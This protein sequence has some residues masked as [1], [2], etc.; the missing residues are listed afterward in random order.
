MVWSLGDVNRKGLPI[1]WF[2]QSKTDI[3]ASRS[4]R[5][6]IFD[7]RFLKKS[8]MYVPNRHTAIFFF[9]FIEGLLT[10]CDREI[11]YVPSGSK[12]VS[13]KILIVS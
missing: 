2:G 10:E 13:V 7:S 5:L 6:Q 9:L 3:C 11:S 8:I 1:A 4:Q 12:F